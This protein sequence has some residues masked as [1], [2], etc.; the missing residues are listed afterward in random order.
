VGLEVRHWRDVSWCRIKVETDVAG[1][2]DTYMRRAGRKNRT[3][4]FIFAVCFGFGGWE[5][6]R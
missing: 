3:K 6:E 4:S 5:V 2:G 1:Q